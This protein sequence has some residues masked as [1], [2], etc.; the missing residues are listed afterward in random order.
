MGVGESDRCSN[1]KEGYS[2]PCSMKST[3]LNGGD[4][5][6]QAEKK[7]NSWWCMN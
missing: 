1:W 6:K 7:T 5:G 4:D 3:L 2:K